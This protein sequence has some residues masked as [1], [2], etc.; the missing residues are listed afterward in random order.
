MWGREVGMD[1]LF[2][3]YSH[4]DQFPLLF[5]VLPYDFFLQEACLGLV[6]PFR[7]LMASSF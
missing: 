7:R 4:P 2:R 3:H 5:Q 6:P 1:T